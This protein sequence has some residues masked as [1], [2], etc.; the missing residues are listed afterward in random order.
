MELSIAPQINFKKIHCGLEI[1]DHVSLPPKHMGSPQ[2]DTVRLKFS[3]T[4]NDTTF[5]P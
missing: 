1:N 2:E 4:P 3:N 5:T